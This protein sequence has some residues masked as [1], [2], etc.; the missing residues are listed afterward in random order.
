MVVVPKVLGAGLA[1]AACA[2]HRKVDICGGLVCVQGGI[3]LKQM[4]ACIENV[5]LGSFIKLTATLQSCLLLKHTYGEISTLD[6]YF[7]HMTW[8]KEAHETGKPRK[9]ISPPIGSC[10]CN[11]LASDFIRPV[12]IEVAVCWQAGSFQNYWLHP[13]FI[14]CI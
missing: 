4:R 9:I 11:S 2:P 8:I 3:S 5:L 14:R 13:S 10:C 1:A 6:K 7:L 12:L